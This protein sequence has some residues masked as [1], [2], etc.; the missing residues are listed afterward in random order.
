[1]VSK[2]FDFENVTLVGIVAADMSLYISDYKAKER[3]FQLITQVS[4]RAGRASKK[5]Q[6]IIQ[7][8]SPDSEIIKYSASGD[9]EDFYNYEI[10]ERKLFL[11]PPYTK[12]V[13]LEFSSYDE[14]LTEAWAEKFLRQMSMDIKNLDLMVTKFIKLPKIKNVNRTKFSVKVKPK[15]LALLIYGLKRVII[16]S[17][18]EEDNKVFLN[19]DFR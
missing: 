17:K 8:Y 9:Y 1:M 5:G 12:L 6:V 7:T 15:D 10:E 4:G 16:N 11:Y 2:G 14:S 18:I 13:E 3:T 19:I